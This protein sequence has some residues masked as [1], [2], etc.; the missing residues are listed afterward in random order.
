MDQGPLVSEQIEAGA[1][2]LREFQK[3]VPVQTAFWLKESESG[4]WYLY[5]ASDRITDDNFDVAYGEVA[6]IAG[7][8][9]DPWFDPFQI[10]VIG[11]DDPLAKG[12]EDLLRLYPGRRPARFRDTTLGGVSVDEVYIYPSPLPVPVQ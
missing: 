11:T 10:K 12:V 6:R 8:I 4:E 9:H 7:A 3:Y 1:R 5:V 2:F